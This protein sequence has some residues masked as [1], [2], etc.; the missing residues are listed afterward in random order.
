MSNE[1]TAGLRWAR[2]QPDSLIIWLDKRRTVPLIFRP[3]PEGEFTMGARGESANEEPPH[4]VMITK[5]FYL[6]AF[7]TT[8]AQ[9]R[10]LVKKWNSECDLNA[11]PSHFKGDLRPVENV[12]WNDSTQWCELLQHDAEFQ[13]QIRE[14]NLIVSCEDLIVSLP[15]EAHW[16]FACR[17]GMETEYYNGDGEAAL[18]EVGW[19][20]KNSGGETKP[21][22]ML[23]RNKNGLYDMHGNVDEWCLDGWD[24][25]AYKCRI[26]KCSDPFV[27][28][29]SQE[30]RRVVRGGS[31]FNIAGFCRS[32]FRIWWGPGVR[33]RDLGFR[34]CLFSGPIQVGKTAK[35]E[36]VPRDGARRDDAAESEGTGVAST[37]DGD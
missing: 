2:S 36:P 4:R 12:S 11:D 19:Y 21:V 18:A 13:K 6:A 30:L 32:A 3:I 20:Q 8:Q 14:Q 1:S 29:K 25:D 35:A 33:F 23:E 26:D 37:Q 24:G 10:V 17:A 16:E 7:P 5:P 15:M 22:G 28:G 9:W 27:P 34:V 31:W